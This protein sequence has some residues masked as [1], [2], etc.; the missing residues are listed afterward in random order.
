MKIT[1]TTVDR[2]PH[3]A[4]GYALYWDDALRGFGLRVTASGVK[5]FVVQQ[6][7]QGREH[8]ITLGRHGV[9]TVEQARKEA[10]RLLGEIAG[11]HDPLAERAR[12]RLKSITLGQAF[13]VYLTVRKDLKA[14]TVS[15]MKVAMKGLSDWMQ[16]PVVSITRDMVARRHAELGQR[17]H[18][19]ANL[20]MRYL[21]AI[22]NF[23]SGQYTDAEGRPLITDN[24]VKRLSDTRAWYRVERRRAFIKPHEL[25]AWFEGVLSLGDKPQR[26]YLLLL[27]LTGLRSRE[28]ITLRWE[29]VD[30]QSR[31]LT[32]PDPKNR[33]PHTLPLADYLF[34]MLQA[35][36]ETR[37]NG[38]VFAGK[39]GVGHLRTAQRA[40]AQVISVSRVRF[41]LHD[42]R[43]SFA[44]VA[45]SLDIPAYA[46]KRL[47]KHREADD[48]TSGYVVVTPERLRGP[49]QKIEDFLLE[50]GG[51]K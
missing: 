41:S 18:A 33:E 16:R 49:M 26:D 4:T 15:D 12:E 51:V 8:R 7:I 27:L 11:G 9:L 22:I 46:L 20:S 25:R 10:K 17:S 47:L 38:Y 2:L 42:L 21:R 48:V 43:R 5:A 34:H 32:I 35:R 44:T 37:T 14:R 39:G 6:R 23:A 40:V 50:K 19:R 13:E 28:A 45:D 3:P 1:K 31:T 29:D 24:P 30:L 36:Y